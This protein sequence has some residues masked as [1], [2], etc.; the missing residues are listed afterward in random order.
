MFF[1]VNGPNDKRHGKRHTAA[2]VYVVHGSSGKHETFRGKGAKMR[3]FGAMARWLKTERHVSVYEHATENAAGKRIADKKGALS[4]NAPKRR[5]HKP[6]RRK[7]HG[8]KTM[9]KRRRR[10]AAKSAPKRRRRRRS[11]AVA[12][13]APK[14][15]ATRRRRK[16]VAKTS[17]RRSRSFR[18]N[19]PI[20][21]DIKN[22]IVDGLSV[23]AGQTATRKLGAAISA[24]LP[25]ASTTNQVAASAQFV[26]TRL[27]GAIAVGIAARKFAP[28]YSRMVVAGAFAEVVNCALAQ[29]PVAPFLSALPRRRLVALPSRTGVPA[30]RAWPGQTPRV[31]AWPTSALPNPGMPRQVG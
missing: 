4:T 13:S 12:H 19:P 3:A 10:K 2:P 29:T 5:A 8:V 27:A 26:G 31:S 30:V 6:K 15:R 25:P 20:L 14:R 23:V 28:K 7:T 1:L 9:A 16:S 24:A 18:R 22:G 11:T 21:S 17:R